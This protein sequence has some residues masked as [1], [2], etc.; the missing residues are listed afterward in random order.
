MKVKC[1]SMVW[2][3]V[4]LAVTSKWRNAYPWVGY[5]TLSSKNFLAVDRYPPLLSHQNDIWEHMSMGQISGILNKIKCSST[6]Y[7]SLWYVSLLAVM[8]KWHMVRH[9]QLSVK[10]EYSRTGYVSPCAMTSKWQK[11]AVIQVRFSAFNESKM[12]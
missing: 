6:G 9:I 12:L 8:T 5:L 11:G 10:V 2:I 7:V 4:F 1:S 3:H